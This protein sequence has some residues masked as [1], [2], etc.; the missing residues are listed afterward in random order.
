MLEILQNFAYSDI[1]CSYAGRSELPDNLKALFRPVS[2]VVPDYNVIAETFLYAEG[3]QEAGYLSRKLVDC[4]QNATEQLSAQTH[5][6]WGLR[7]IKTVLCVAGTLRR[8]ETV[9]FSL[10][11][12][13]IHKFIITQ[14]SI[15][16]KTVAE[17]NLFV[18]ALRESSITKLVAPDI[19]IFDTI[20]SRL[21]PS[22]PLSLYLFITYLLYSVFD[23]EYVR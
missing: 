2:M 5:Y 7:A 17:A 12:V 18:K 21:F 15:G 6:D 10:F 22:I 11:A 3:F 8:Q 9:F 19:P 16:T 13:T 14:A 23:K 1:T 4:F 20:V